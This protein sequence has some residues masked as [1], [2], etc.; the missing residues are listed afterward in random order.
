MLR[1]VCSISFDTQ[2][3]RLNLRQRASKM[4]PVGI[5]SQAMPVTAHLRYLLIS[6]APL[7][8]SNYLFSYVGPH[9]TNWNTNPV[10]TEVLCFHRR[11]NI[12]PP[13]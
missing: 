2:H 10:S 6:Q 13:V 3:I 11:V 7:L 9:K 4:R 5:W 12:D 1:V 8:E